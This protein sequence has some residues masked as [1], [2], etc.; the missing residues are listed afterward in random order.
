MKPTER[1]SIYNSTYLILDTL[2]PLKR[3]CFATLYTALYNCSPCGG[4]SCKIIMDNV[5]SSKIFTLLFTN[6]CL[7]P[8]MRHYLWD[9]ENNERSVKQRTSE[10]IIR[11][12][13][14]V[15]R[16]IL[17]KF[18]E[19]HHFL[20]FNMTIYQAEMI[21]LPLKVSRIATTCFSLITIKCVGNV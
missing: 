9:N 17:L 10:T 16:E 5:L 20:F 14:Q 6:R 3:D 8:K 7:Y 1:I 2:W 4:K 15:S 18:V 21:R 12:Q 11:C 19:I 13:C